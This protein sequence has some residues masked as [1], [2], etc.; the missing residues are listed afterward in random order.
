MM[1]RLFELRGK[2]DS[3]TNLV[4]ILLGFVLII[5]FWSFLTAGVDPIIPSGIL[6]KPG[7][8]LKAF[9]LLVSENSLFKNMCFSL[10]LNIMSYTEAISI[11][12]A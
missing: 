12:L 4:L 10:G 11:S 5:L 7:A 8:V 6:C 1:E 2:L 9:P 3:K